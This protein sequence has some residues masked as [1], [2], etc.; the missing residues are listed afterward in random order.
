MIA[1]RKRYLEAMAATLEVWAVQIGDL[2]V[3][4]RS[5][6]G[7]QRVMIDRQIVALGQERLKYES[8]MND[9]RDTSAGMLRE[10]RKAAEPV[11]AEFRRLYVQTASRFPS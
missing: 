1:E 8:R 3:K 11:A 10:M 6:R 4:A 5:A 7:E 9:T 2:Q